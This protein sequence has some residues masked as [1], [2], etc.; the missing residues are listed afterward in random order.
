MATKPTYDANAVNPAGLHEVTVTNADGHQTIVRV[1]ADSATDAERL[2]AA[3]LEA[4]AAALPGVTAVAGPDDI[5]ARERD[6]DQE[7]TRAAVEFRDG[8]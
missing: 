6:A 5:R 8:A 2:V 7:R 3:R 1:T 4:A